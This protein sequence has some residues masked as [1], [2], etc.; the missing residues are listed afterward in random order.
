M[1][2]VIFEYTL[3]SKANDETTY[4]IFKLLDTFGSGA[5]TLN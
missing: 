2:L 4:N 1:T 3:I 5:L